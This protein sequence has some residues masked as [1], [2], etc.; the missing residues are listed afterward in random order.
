MCTDIEGTLKFTR[1]AETAFDI[2]FTI[3]IFISMM[4]YSSKKEYETSKDLKPLYR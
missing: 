4:T 2:I 1:P 3:N